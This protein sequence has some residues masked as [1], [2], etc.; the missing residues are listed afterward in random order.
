MPALS[1]LA[2]RA[3]PLLDLTNVEDDCTAAVARALCEKALSSPAAPAAVC[4]RPAF[5]GMAKALLAGSGIRLATVVNFPDATLTSEQAGRRCDP[6]L[7]SEA[8]RQALADGADEIDLVFAWRAFLDG[9]RDSPRQAVEAVR[10]ACGPAVLKVILESGAY[11][12]PASLRA[13]CDL[14][15]DAGADFLKTSTTRLSPAATPEAVA[16]LCQASRAVGKLVGVK[17]SGG[18]RTPE[19]AQHY[20]DIIADHMGLNWI[21]AAHVRIGAS[22]LLE[23]LLG[24]PVPETVGY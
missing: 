6:V 15:I 23:A 11:P 10:A 4:L 17:V 20:L 22:K 9:D 19:Q 12:D 18:V 3:I 16:V 14:V 1:P 24:L 2:K 8:T 13:A 21:E 5:L 7:L